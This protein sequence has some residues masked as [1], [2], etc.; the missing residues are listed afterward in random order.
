MTNC[1]FCSKELRGNK[2]S[3]AAHESCCKFNPNRKVRVRSIKAGAQKGNIPWNKGLQSD[4]KILDSVKLIESKQYFHLVEPTIRK[5]MR[6]Y[7]IYTYGN[8][9]SICNESKWMGKDIPLVTDHIDGNS[10]NNMI[11]NYR[12]VCCNC[13]A[14]L[15]TYKSKNNGNGRKYDRIYK[16]ER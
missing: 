2:G 16:K 11:E 9:C 10:T 5:H 13:D 3:V 8:K 14:Q 12:M 7:L 4:K 6:R 15:A 1:K